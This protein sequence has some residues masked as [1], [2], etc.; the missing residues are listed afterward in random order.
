M[1]LIVQI[2]QCFDRSGESR[3]RRHIVDAPSGMPNLA[4][5]AERAD[6][7]GTR[8]SRHDNEAPS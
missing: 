7:I 3:V 4:S 6:V 8:P 2:S 5:I 1:L